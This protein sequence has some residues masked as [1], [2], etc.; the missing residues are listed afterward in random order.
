MTPHKSS[1]LI[2]VLANVSVHARVGP[3]LARSRTCLSLLISV[4]RHKAVDES[5][6]LVLSA[7]ATLNN[8]TFYTR[9]QP[10]S[11]LHTQLAE[12]RFWF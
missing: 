3:V 8:L 12:C 11:A 7:L 6:E 4:L 10:V 2:R 9:D 5:E 1:Q